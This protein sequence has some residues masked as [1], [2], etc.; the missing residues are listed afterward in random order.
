MGQ[1]STQHRLAYL[2]ATR[3]IKGNYTF[4]FCKTKQCWIV[5]G[6]GIEPQ[7]VAENRDYLFY[8]IGKGTLDYLKENNTKN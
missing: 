7:K 5:S 1:K 3:C 2:L 4:N 8:Y 6:E